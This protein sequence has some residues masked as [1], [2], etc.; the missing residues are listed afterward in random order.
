MS[1]YLNFR[2]TFTN[3]GGHTKFFKFLPVKLNSYPEISV[4]FLFKFELDVDSFGSRRGV[5]HS[6]VVSAVALVFNSPA[7]YYFYIIPRRSQRDIVLVSS[8]RTSVCPFPP[9]VHTFCLSGTISQY[10]LVRFD[11]FLVKMISTMT[12]RYP[13]SL[14]K[15]DPLTLE[16]LSPDKVRGI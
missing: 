2:G 8:V 14:V 9:S 16:L 4:H 11:S 5:E 10:L 6:E 13:I 12:S 7:N 3:S 1:L 15:I